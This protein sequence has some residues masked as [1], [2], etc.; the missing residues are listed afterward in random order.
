LHQDRAGDQKGVRYHAAVGVEAGGA[1][2]RLL[3]GGQAGE[4]FE[5]GRQMRDRLDPRD[6]EAADVRGRLG[7]TIAAH[8]WIRRAYGAEPK[9]LLFAQL[10]P[11]VSG[12]F[13]PATGAVSIDPE[14]L[15]EDDPLEV[16]KPL[17]HENRHD[18]QDRIIQE[19][20][21]RQD[22][23]EAAVSTTE[24][25]IWDHADTN[26]TTEDL[27]L[28]HYNALEVDAR[29]AEGEFERG[30]LRRHIEHLSGE[31]PPRARSRIALRNRAPRRGQ[32]GLGR[33]RGE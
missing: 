17:A 22:A 3:Q 25:R 20:R 2:P 30:F 24:M 18:V 16:L 12:E 14:L 8:D 26:Y 29:E 28:Y 13:E 27:D 4:V 31:Q 19:H 1:I 23:E 15:F 32:Q 5:L 33:E 11:E 7:M 9:R 21:Q 10:P 6:W